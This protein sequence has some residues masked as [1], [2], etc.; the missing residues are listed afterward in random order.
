MNERSSRPPP[1]DW[2]DET[3]KAML[4]R[5]TKGIKITRIRLLSNIF[6]LEEGDRIKVRWTEETREPFRNQ[7]EVLCTQNANVGYIRF[8]YR[9]T[10]SNEIIL[11][12]K[13]LTFMTYFDQPSVKEGVLELTEVGELRHPQGTKEY[14]E[15]DF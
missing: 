2:D 14:G 13:T 9:D 10:E 8:A 7:R 4:R 15:L 5:A 6:D 12:T 11:L 1:N 3:G